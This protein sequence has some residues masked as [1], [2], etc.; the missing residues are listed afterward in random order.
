M[1]PPAIPLMSRCCGVVTGPQPWGVVTSHVGLLAFCRPG[2]S[3]PGSRDGARTDEAG[4]AAVQAE[5]LLK[6]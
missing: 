4:S 5:A 1:P 6:C 3:E 2:T